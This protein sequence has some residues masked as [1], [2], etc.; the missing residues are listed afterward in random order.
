MIRRIFM[1]SILGAVLILTGCTSHEP[2][3]SLVP[4]YSK[5]DVDGQTASTD[6]IASATENDT[7]QSGTDIASPIEA[8]TLEQ[9]RKELNLTLSFPMTAQNVQ[10]INGDPTIYEM[11]FTQDSYVFNFRFARTD[12]LED[13][14]SMYYDW[15]R[16][17][18]DPTAD[19]LYSC[20]FTDEGQGICQW[21]QDG[22]SMSLSMD[23]NASEEAFSELYP[24]IA[25]NFQPTALAL[26]FSAD[27]VS[28]VDMY[29]YDSVPAD[30]QKKVL[31]SEKD[32]KKLYETLSGLS[33]KSTTTEDMVGSEVT[34]FRFHLSDSTTCDFIYCY[35]GF[36]KG[37]FSTETS[38]YTVT[39]D[40]TSLWNTL[41]KD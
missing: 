14:S 8:T 20:K 3:A 33:L 4:S 15:T 2:A 1:A 22:Y 32:I 16:S 25:E 40:L 36:R 41:A 9:L 5:G 24:L 10:K 17:T 34:S 21:M 38:T 27:T 26:S 19:Q 7:E 37:K 28:S 39:T 30:A 13:I 35:Y 18:E 31:T 23:T 12:T 11:D 29:H 6:T